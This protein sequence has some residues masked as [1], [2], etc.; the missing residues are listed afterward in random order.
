MNKY[1]FYFFASILSSFIGIAQSITTIKG[2]APEYID[3]NIE[4]NEISDF[5]SYRE[6]IVAITTV[7]EDSTFSMSF[8]NT[9]IR[10]VVIRS[11]NNYSYIY[12]E[13]GKTYEIYLPLHDK[14]KPY[15][16]LGNYVTAIFLN[17]DTNDIN[18]KIIEFDNLIDRFY[19]LNLYD[20]VRDKQQFLN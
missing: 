12:I 15:R 17:L 19:A 10:K 11:N 16:S 1:F 6:S 9:E 8:E 13:P 14:E 4:I 3:K 2:Y 18:H 20:F 7:K 5:L